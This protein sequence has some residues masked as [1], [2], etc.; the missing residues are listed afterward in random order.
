MNGAV[1]LLPAMIMAAMSVILLS[2]EIV[3]LKIATVDKQMIQYIVM[4]RWCASLSR[5][6]KRPGPATT[7][8]PKWPSVDESI[9][10]V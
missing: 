4:N 5:S 1:M 6:V 9:R 10:I 7:T 8:T 2:V 3:M